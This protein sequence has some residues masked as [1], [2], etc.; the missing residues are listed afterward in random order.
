[1]SEVVKKKVK[2]LKAKYVQEAQSIAILGE[3]DQGRLIHQIHKSAFSFGNRSEAEVI[4]ELEKTAA[5]M[6]GKYINIVYDP[7]LNGRIKDHVALKY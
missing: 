3:C 6:V 2:V 7:D 4:K 5:M 1:M